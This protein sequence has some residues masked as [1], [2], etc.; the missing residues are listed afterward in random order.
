[1]STDLKSK[2]RDKLE[3]CAEEFNLEDFSYGSFYR[4][5]GYKSFVSAADVVYSTGDE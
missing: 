2:L 4:Q 5:Q 1:M 3:E